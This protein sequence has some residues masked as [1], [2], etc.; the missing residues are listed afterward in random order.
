MKMLLCYFW[1]SLI[2]VRFRGVIDFFQA[3]ADNLVHN[4]VLGNKGAKY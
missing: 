2:G 3:A 4:N 1:S